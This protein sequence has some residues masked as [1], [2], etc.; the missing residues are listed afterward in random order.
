MMLEALVALAQG[1]LAALVERGANLDVQAL[2]LVGFDAALSAAVVAAQQ[3]LGHLWWIPVPGLVVSTVAGG[4][5]MAV[6][7]FDLGPSPSDFYSRNRSKGDAD[8]LAQLLA[9]LLAAQERNAE[10]LRMKTGRLVIA[11]A[12]LLLTVVYSVVLIVAF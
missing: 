5:V 4:S 6:T 10:P 1:Q 7:R 9:D 11:L 8:G 3:I 2:G 12:S